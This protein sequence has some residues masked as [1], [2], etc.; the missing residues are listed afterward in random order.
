[1]ISNL[2]KGIKNSV[3]DI[4]G[5]FLFIKTGSNSGIQVTLKPRGDL[6]VKPLGPTGLPEIAHFAEESQVVPAYVVPPKSPTNHV[7]TLPPFT[8]PTEVR[9]SLSNPISQSIITYS[10][11]F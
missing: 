2:I 3:R 4:C 1:M 9:N 10:M 11:Y 7:S 8:P 5:K 6:G